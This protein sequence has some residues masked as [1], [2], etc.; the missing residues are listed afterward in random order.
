MGADTVCTEPSLYQMSTMARANSTSLLS[1]D[2]TS[3][4]LMPGR[5]FTLLLQRPSHADQDAGV[6]FTSTRRVS[7]IFAC[8]LS[9][10][11]AAVVYRNPF[12]VP[13]VVETVRLVGICV[14][15]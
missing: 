9:V 1:R 12:W 7:T 15:T 5:R 6:P 4:R 3:T 13:S 10:T 2:C 11:P 14:R 8:P